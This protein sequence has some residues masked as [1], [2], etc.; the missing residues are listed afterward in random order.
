M[1]YVIIVIFFDTEVVVPVYKQ[2]ETRKF[3]FYTSKIR[4][5]KVWQEICAAVT[6]A[7]VTVNDSVTVF[8]TD[9]AT[10]TV[11]IIIIII[12]ILLK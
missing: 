12:V 3:I 2:D 11:T 5:T 1:I 7:A 9:F 4:I 6:I 10:I 8:V